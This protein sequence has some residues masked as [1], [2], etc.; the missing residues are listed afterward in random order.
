MKTISIYL[1]AFCTIVSGLC[2]KDAPK[3]Y[4]EIAAT[5][6]S[7]IQNHDASLYTSIR[8]PE[9]IESDSYTWKSNPFPFPYEALSE[10]LKGGFTMAYIESAPAKKPEHTMALWK[11]I[12]ADEKSD[13]FFI[14]Y[15]KN[16]LVT[17][18]YGGEV[19]SARESVKEK[20]P[21]VSLD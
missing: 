17:G 9:G 20:F 13:W 6:F 19:K 16:N 12:F 5:L 11:L 2:A 4:S 7:A 14:I 10:R 21:A 15:T 1:L 8:A 18:T 3:E